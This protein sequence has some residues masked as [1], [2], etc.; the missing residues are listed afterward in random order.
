MIYDNAGRWIEGQ[1]L[2]EFASLPFHERLKWVREE[3]NK[4][5]VGDYSVK[6]V[7]V[8]SGVISHM[9][10]YNM[11]SN[12]DSRPRPQKLQGL[13]DFYQVPISIFTANA[14][15]RFFLGKQYEDGEGTSDIRG[16]NYTVEINF[17]LRTPEGAET[18]HES[19]SLKMR[20]MDAEELLSRLQ[21][22][23]S[24]VQKRLD[25]Q[26]KLDEAYDLLTKK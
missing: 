3:L 16:A 25:Q 21:N 18:I 26:R 8:T 22:E 5:Y 19:L 14:P 2:A 1:E 11:E 6:K 12:E 7:A 20:H 17:S 13:A 9:G 10:L 24:L 23:L 4:V 15:D